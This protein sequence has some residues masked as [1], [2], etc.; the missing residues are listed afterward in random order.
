MG[1]EFV[2]NL[3]SVMGGLPTLDTNPLFHS[4]ISHKDINDHLM[5]HRD[6]TSLPP[7]DVLVRTSGVKRLS[8]SFSGGYAWLLMHLTDGRLIPARNPIGSAASWLRGY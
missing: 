1:R 2:I 7:V 5:A 3:E 8:V 4:S 6:S